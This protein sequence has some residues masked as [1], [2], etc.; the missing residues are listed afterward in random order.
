MVTGAFFGP[1]MGAPFRLMLS[2]T[3]GAGAA[4]GAAAAGAAGALAIASSI[5]LVYSCSGFTP[6]ANMSL[7]A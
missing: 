2:T 4:A 7:A 1:L 5:S 6:L 3:T